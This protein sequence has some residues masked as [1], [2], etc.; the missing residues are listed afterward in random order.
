MMS[1]V[2]P[3]MTHIQQD[4]TMSCW[5]ASAQMLVKWR[6]DKLRMTTANLLDPSEEAAARK[7][8]DSNTGIVNDAILKFAH[9]LGLRSVPP[10]SPT[11]QALESWL[12]AYGPLWVNGKNHIVVLAGIRDG[13]DVLVYDPAYG[14]PKGIEWRS[15]AGWYVGSTSSSRDTAKDVQAV[16]LHCPA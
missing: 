7:L 16:F 6:R 9:K 13:K 12:K 15:L 2:V 5:F 1:Y 3:G 14:L 8:Y 10:M 11:P 4:K